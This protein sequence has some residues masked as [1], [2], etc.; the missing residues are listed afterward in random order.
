MDNAAKPVIHGREGTMVG[1]G[2]VLLP[3]F[4]WLSYRVAFVQPTPAA[5]AAWGLC[6]ALGHIPGPGFLH[7]SFVCAFCSFLARPQVPAN[8]MPAFTGTQCECKQSALLQRQEHI[9]AVRKNENKLDWED[10]MG[11][12]RGQVLSNAGCWK[13]RVYF[14]KIYNNKSSCLHFKGWFFLYIKNMLHFSSN[15]CKWRDI[16]YNYLV[17]IVKIYSCVIFTSKTFI[18]I[19]KSEMS[20]WF[21]LL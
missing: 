15:Y 19:Y 10:N 18:V 7:L 9:P 13:N 3:F 5:P 12:C 16:L 17:C 14:S 20:I 4:R 11:R 6:V 8:R 21:W 2:G 1:K